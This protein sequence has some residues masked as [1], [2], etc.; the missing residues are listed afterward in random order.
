MPQPPFASK[1]TPAAGI[2]AGKM[3]QGGARAS[4]LLQ[5]VSHLLRKCQSL[6]KNRILSTVVPL[7]YRS[8]FSTTFLREIIP[9]TLVASSKVKEGLE[10]KKKLVYPSKMK[11]EL[12]DPNV[13]VRPVK[14]SVIFSNP[15]D[16]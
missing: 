3:G 15:S 2:N 11:I 13:V 14:E 1:Q 9:E 6:Y 5:A 4:S 10:E 16:L 7:R 8:L 12:I